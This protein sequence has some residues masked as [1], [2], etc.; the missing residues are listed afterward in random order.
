MKL[1]K[2]DLFYHCI[3]I[4]II[5]ILTIYSADKTSKNRKLEER[6]EWYKFSEEFWREAAYRNAKE[7]EDLY[8][9]HVDSTYNFFFDM[10]Q[11]M[12]DSLYPKK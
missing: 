10:P 1:K 2:L 7:F 12:I 9:D 3:I 11:G 6:I 4:L 8:H 5:I